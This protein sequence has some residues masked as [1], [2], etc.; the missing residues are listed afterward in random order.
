MIL[1][2]LRPILSHGLASA[3]VAVVGAALIALF[4]VILP[5]EDAGK[6]LSI[7]EFVAVGAASLF[8]A[9]TLLLLAVR[10]FRNVRSEIHGS[11]DPTADTPSSNP[12]A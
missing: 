9:N 1:N 7:E 2:E 12:G 8:A 3:S 11:Q 5:A 6:L 10:V 4:R